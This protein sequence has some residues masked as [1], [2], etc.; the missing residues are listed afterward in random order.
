MKCSRCGGDSD[1]L[2]TRTRKAG[3]YRRRVCASCGLRWSTL[4]T[5]AR[6]RT[7]EELSRKAREQAGPARRVT[8]DVWAGVR[9]AL[10]FEE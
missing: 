3:T 1:V 8:Q 9:K 6:E 2:Q 10:G 5:R 7:F 4:E